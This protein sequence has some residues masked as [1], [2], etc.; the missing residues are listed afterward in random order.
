MADERDSDVE[1]DEVGRA[2]EEIIGTEE[3]DEEFEDVDTE[4]E[5]AEEEE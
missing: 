3:D 1:N 4:D 2:D 5:D